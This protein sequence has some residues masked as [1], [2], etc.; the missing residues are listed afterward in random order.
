VIAVT[1]SNLIQDL[2]DAGSLGSLYALVA[3]GI[4]L[5]FGVMRLINFAHGELITLT[6]YSCLLFAGHG[7]VALFVGPLTV[8]VVAALAM[9]RLAFRPVRAANPA[10]LLITS[11]TL[12][13]LIQNALTSIF[14]ST[15]RSVGLP[16]TVIET[17][18]IGSVQIPKLSLFTIALATVLLAGVAAFL[19]KAPIGIY[20]RAAAEDFQMARLLGVRANTVIAA[21][22]AVSGLLA[23]VVGLIF[24]A[25]TGAVTPTLGVSL[26]LIGFVATVVG[27][28]GSMSAAAAGGFVLGIITVA[29]Q[30][31]LPLNLRPYRDAF[32]FAAVIVILLARPQGL[33]VRSGGGRG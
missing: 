13:Y 33:L 14:S 24:V 15:T 4:A 6:A 32:L 9:E 7:W 20:M 31:A 3:L 30:D 28:M 27:G 5:I 16:Q 18:T 21:A 26:A 11:F 12:S 29:L 22:F 2:V 23:G 19:K 8:A 10:T 17:F 25:Q 1:L